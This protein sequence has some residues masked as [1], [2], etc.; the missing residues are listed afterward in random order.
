[1]KRFLIVYVW[2]SIALYGKRT[3]TLLRM[4]ADVIAWLTATGWDDST[5]NPDLTS[6]KSSFSPTGAVEEDNLGSKKQQ[7]SGKRKLSYALCMYVHIMY[8]CTYNIKGW[9]DEVHC[10]ERNGAAKAVAL[11]VLGIGGV[12]PAACYGFEEVGYR[13]L[14]PRAGDGLSI[15]QPPAISELG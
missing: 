1:M 4:P 5:A 12:R 9:V 11:T 10:Y 13:T 6:P 2:H 3:A 7:S 8:V 15:D 14:L